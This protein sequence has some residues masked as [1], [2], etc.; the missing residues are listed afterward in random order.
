MFKKTGTISSNVIISSMVYACTN[1]DHTEVITG[2]VEK[3]KTCPKCQDKMVLISSHVE[4][5]DESTSSS[6]SSE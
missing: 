1:C 6:E 3:T 5:S 2:D 4:K